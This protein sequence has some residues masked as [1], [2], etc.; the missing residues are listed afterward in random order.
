MTAALALVLGLAPA[1][2]AV[3]PAS[4]MESR[5]V[6]E[7]FRDACTRGQVKL[8]KSARII[9]EKDLPHY[10]KVFDTWINW[11]NQKYIEFTSPGSTYVLLADLAKPQ[12][13]SL[14][15]RCMV[16]SRALT[17]RDAAYALIESTPEI[18]PRQTWVPAM[19]LPEWVIDL[20]KQ[21]YQKRLF[22]AR[23]GTVYLEVG[24]YTSALN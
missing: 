14:A 17:H 22:I 7:L 24:T 4:A 11:T 6:V 18:E 10:A 16:V 15:R 1:P 2:S 8:A 21:G 19:H 23:D 3:Q 5:A 13:K 20:P 12:P 9:G